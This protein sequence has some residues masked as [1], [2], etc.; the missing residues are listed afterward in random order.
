MIAASVASALRVHVRPRMGTLLALTLEGPRSVSDRAA[1]HAFALAADLERM[2]T[3]LNESSDL[4]RVGQAAGWFVPVPAELARALRLARRLAAITGGAFDPTVG[5]L[6]DVWRG[7]DGSDAR[8]ARARL[9]V[10]RASVD[11]RRLDV[12]ERAVRLRERGMALDLDGFGKGWAADRIALGLRRLGGLAALVNFGESSI[13]AIGGSRPGHGWPVLV[14]DPRG[15]FAGAFML[16]NRACSTSATRRWTSSRPVEA[17]PCIIDPHSGRQLPGIAQVTVIARTAAIAEAASTAMLV[18]GRLNMERIA[19]RL[20]AEACW[21]DHAG[22]ITTPSFH[23]K[24]VPPRN[25]G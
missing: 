13:V 5:P 1:Q 11:W 19:S 12:R 22:I 24:P 18:L 23:L 17:A 8:P 6:V 15:G 10:A 25:L 4:N 3:R 9:A 16:A 20:R 7:A 14:R 21:I 2:M